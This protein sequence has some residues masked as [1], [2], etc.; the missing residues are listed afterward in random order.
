MAKMLFFVAFPSPDI[1]GTFKFNE[2]LTFKIKMKLKE[3]K[4]FTKK[5]EEGLENMICLPPLKRILI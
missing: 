1:F 5:D 4:R 3:K 2:N